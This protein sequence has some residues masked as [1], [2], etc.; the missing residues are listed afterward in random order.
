[1]TCLIEFRLLQVCRD[2]LMPFTGV[3]VSIS[4]HGFAIAI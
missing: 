1:L 4:I 2:V 3:V